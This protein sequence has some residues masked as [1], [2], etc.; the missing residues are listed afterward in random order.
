MRT[1]L[2]LGLCLVA[3]DAPVEQQMRADTTSVEQL[4]LASNPPAVLTA[5]RAL[6]AADPNAAFV[7]V[8]AN[9]RPRVRTVITSA[10]DSSFTIWIATRP[11]TRKVEQIRNNARVALYYNDD[12]QSS[13]VSIMGKATLHTDRA[14]LDAKN[15]YGAE[16]TRAFFP[17]YPADMVLI[18]VKPDWI[19]VIGAGIRADSSTWR[20]QATVLR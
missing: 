1:V 2:F 17:N 8:D 10:P 16:R 20:P 12:S 6:I 14:I 13:Y 9:G 4:N 11:T 3:C 15:F 19:E 7:T 5:A 18:E